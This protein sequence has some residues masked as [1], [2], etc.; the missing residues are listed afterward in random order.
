MLRYKQIKEKYPLTLEL[1]KA[2]PW[3]SFLRVTG[4]P[5]FILA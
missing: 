4:I 5:V 3:Q 2:K 1:K